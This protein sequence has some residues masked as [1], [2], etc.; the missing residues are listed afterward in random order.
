MPTLTEKY[1]FCITDKEGG[2]PVSS[3]MHCASGKT[4][5][6]AMCKDDFSPVESSNICAK[7]LD[8]NQGPCEFDA[9][10]FF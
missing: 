4:I 3:Q 5:S 9:G 2:K 8:P 10:I 6:L 7:T 1:I